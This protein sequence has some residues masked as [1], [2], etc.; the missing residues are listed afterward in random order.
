MAA[1]HSLRRVFV[2]LVRQG[3]FRPLA[4]ISD[5]PAGTPGED[6]A[7]IAPEHEKAVV[8]VARWLRAQLRAFLVA[9]TL[10]V[11]TGDINVQLPA[12][13]T[14]MHFVR[15]HAFTEKGQNQEG[16]SQDGSVEGAAAER[17]VFGV[18]TF[19]DLVRVLV[20]LIPLL[21]LQ[22]CHARGG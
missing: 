6:A 8:K 17:L 21:W 20:R 12:L 2:G 1:V 10:L 15:L 19:N 13:R 16:V 14:I 22:W 18:D 9:T 5:G 4:E 11:A 3:R 7:Q